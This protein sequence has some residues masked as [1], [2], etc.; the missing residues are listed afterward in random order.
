M[1]QNWNPDDLG[2]GNTGTQNVGEGT[3]Y[4]R[5]SGNGGTIFVVVVF[6]VGLGVI[7]YLGQ[8]N[9][10]EV[11]P[12]GG[13]LGREYDEKTQ[14]ITQ[15][16]GGKGAAN[17]EKMVAMFYNYP[18]LP[19][20]LQ[21]TMRNDPFVNPT[22]VAIVQ[23]DERAKNK[24]LVDP[25][26]NNQN[27]GVGVDMMRLDEQRR[28]QARLTQLAEQMVVQLTMI[29]STGNSALIDNKLVSTGAT[30]GEF[31]VVEIQADK[32]ILSAGGMSFTRIV[33]GTNKAP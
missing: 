13:S 16:L 30:L 27:T 33:R 11:E 10:P 9:T 6:L 4:R 17:T 20:E 7:Y 21:G 18:N 29:N 23:A 24:T 1:T 19:A 28:E 8:R 5:K 25:L 26:P 31:K 14:N 2:A 22:E 12:D 32:V 15:A 3:G